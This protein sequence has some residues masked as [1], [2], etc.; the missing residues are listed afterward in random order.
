MLIIVPSEAGLDVLVSHAEF[1]QLPAALMIIS[2]VMFVV[3]NT[4]VENYFF[5]LC[6]RFELSTYVENYFFL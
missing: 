1:V 2:F 6:L 4:Y 5:V 3:I